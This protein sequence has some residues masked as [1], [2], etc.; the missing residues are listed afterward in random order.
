MPNKTIYIS[1]DDRD[2]VERATAIAGGF[3]PAVAQALRRYVDAHDLADR[4]FEQVEVTTRTAGVDAVKIFRGR[5]LARVEQFREGRSVQWTSYSTPRGNIAVV[6]TESPDFIGTAQHGSEAFRDR[7]GFD[8]GALIDAVRQRSGDRT[9]PW[10]S[11]DDLGGLFS[12]VDRIVEQARR[13]GNPGWSTMAEQLF[14]HRPEETRK[15]DSAGRRGFG[16]PIP[17]S[18]EGWT[19]D[20]SDP[21]DERSDT[22]TA[23]HPTASSGPSHLPGSSDL[24]VFG[25]VSELR[26]AAFRD[27]D[28]G[29]GNVI[30]VSFITATERALETPPV[31]FL[32]I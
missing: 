21:A 16:A 7:T 15:E 11:M 6:T 18:S 20:D 24:E 8:P 23:E 26:D 12:M 3:S 1:D 25:S 32:D 28:N 10:S 5:R 14:G 2:L 4:G 30:P 19:G 29:E 31:E 9:M 17:L 22:D 27:D 13:A